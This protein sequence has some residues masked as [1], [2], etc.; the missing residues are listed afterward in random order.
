M[1]TEAVEGFSLS[2]QQ[3]QLWSLQR[4]NRRMPRRAQAA[5]LIEG[6]LDEAALDEAL[7]RVVRRHE[8]LRTEFQRPSGAEFPV[9]VIGDDSPPPVRRVRIDDAEG[10]PRRAWAALLSEAGGGAADEEGGPALRLSLARLSPER[11]LLHADL[12]SMSADAEGLSALVRE[13]ARAYAGAGEPDETLQ[14]AD[15]AESFNQ[16]AEADEMRTAAEFWR[17]RDFTA[18]LHASLPFESGTGAQG[19]F[20]P[21]LLELSIDGA[22]AGRVAAAAASV[23]ADVPLFMQTCWYVLLWKLTRET[24]VTAAVTFDGRAF[25][26]LGDLPGLFAQAVPVT[27]PVEGGIGLAEVAR[28]LKAANEEAR[29]RQ[30]AFSFEELSRRSDDGHSPVAFFPFG[31]EFTS[32]PARVEAGGLTWTLIGQRV[33]A[34]RF[35]VKLRCSGDAGRCDSAELQ[36]DRGRLSRES[37][38]RVARYYGRLLASAGS[39][40]AKVGELEMLDDAERRRLVYELNDTREG[41]ATNLCLHEPFEART[42]QD[43]DSVAL[44]FGSESLSYAQLDRRAATLARRLVASGLPPDATVAVLCRRSLEMPAA[45]LGVLKAGAAYLPLDPDYPA[46][47]LRFMLEDSGAR[48]LVAE[49]ELA[50]ELGA[51]GLP[52]VELPSGEAGW[53]EAEAAAPASDDPPVVGPDNLAYV[54]YTSGST[55]RP[56]GVMVT[57]RGVVN[58]LQWM[59]KAYGLDASDS[60][61]FK[62]SLGFDPSV[63][64]LFWPLWVGARCVIAEPGGQADPAYLL[65]LIADERVTSAYFVPS[66]LRE[67]VE[68]EGLEEAGRSLRRVICGGEALPVEVMRRFMERAPETELHHSYGPTETSIAATEWTCEAEAPRALMGRPLGNV[69]VYVLGPGME[70]LPEGVAG[71][72]F[73]GG[74][75]LARGYS[76]RPA[77]TAERFVPDPF[78]EGSGARLYRTGDVVRWAGPG[79]LLYVGRE[80]GQVKVRGFRIELGEV[81]AA[82]RR[83][84]AVSDAVV[85]ARESADGDKQLVAY[86]LGDGGPAPRA[87]EL[88]EHM[89]RSVPG[90]MIPQAFVALK[91]WPLTVTGKV[92]KKALPEPEAARQDGGGLTFRPMSPAEEVLAAIWSRVLGVEHVGP[93]DNFFDLGGDSIRSV[94]VVALAKERGLRL[95]VQQLFRSQTLA[96]LALDLDLGGGDADAPPTAPFSLVSAQDRALMP[97]DVEDAYPLSMMQAAMLYHMEMTTGAPAY[98][99]LS[100]WHVRARFDD[101]ALREAIRQVIARHAVLRTSFDVTTYSR[102]LQLVHRDA[103]TPYESEDV[104]HLPPDE[105]E[106]HIQRFLDERRDRVFD[107]SR[108][109]QVH[110]VAHRR[111]DD[112]F[113]LTL[114]ENHAVLDGWSVTSTLAEI[115]ERYLALIEGREAPSLSPPAA[116]FRDFVNLELHALASEETR[117]H[118]QRQ[119]SGAT[120]LRL[121]RPPR[122]AE[123]ADGRRVEKVQL[124]LDPEVLEGLKRAARSLAVPLKTVAFA[125]HLKVLSLLS[126]QTD[127]LAGITTNGRP[128][129]SGGTQVRGNFLNTVPFRFELRAETWG[130]MIRRVFEGEWAMLRHRRYPL[131]ALQKSWGRE[132]LLETNFAFLHFHSMDDVLSTGKVKVVGDEAIDLAETNFALLTHFDINSTSLDKR[133]W[134]DMQFDVTLTSPELRAAAPG[135]YD[136]VLRAIAADTSARHEADSYLS[137]EERER[138]LYEWNQTGAAVPAA[139]FQEMFAEQARRTPDAVAVVFGDERLTYRELNERADE[140]AEHLCAFDVGLDTLVAVMLERS[141]EMMVSLVG[142][143]K[144]GAAYLP[145]D[146]TN[147]A[148]RLSF[149]LEDSAAPVLLTQ[150]RLAERLPANA[151]RVIFADGKLEDCDKPGPH[152]P[153]AAMPAHTAYVIYTSGSTGKP[154][155]AAV[156]HRGL[157][158]YLHWC[159]G[160]Y[161]VGEGEGALVHSSIS[162][163]LTVTGLFA[164]L[165][166]GR[167][168]VLAP[169]SVGVEPLAESFRRW[170]DLSLVKI[171]PAQLQLLGGQL[172][173]A[174]AAGG[175]RRFVIGGENLQGETLRFWR[176]AA[177]ETVLINEYGPT[178]TV[179]GCCVHQVRAGE[180]LEGPV[181]IGRP[182]ANTRLYVLDKFMQPTPAGVPGELYIGGEGLARGYLRRPALTAERFVPDPF[183]REPGARL[184]RTGDVCRYRADGEL[185]FLGRADDQLKI[186]GYRIETGEV[187]AS[188]AQHA[189]VREAF[190]TAFEGPGGD[191]H[192]VA[193]LVAEGEPPAA[194]ELR[195]FLKLGLPEYMIP[196]AFVYLDALPLTVAGKVD[197]RALPAPDTQHPSLAAAYVAPHGEVEAIIADVWR[198]VLGVERVGA[199]DNFFDL[200]GDSFGVYEVFNK[201]RVAL[202]GR[203]LSILDLFTHPTVTTL[204]AHIE[205]L[206]G[207]RAEAADAE[208]QE[209]ARKRSLAD[210]RRAAARSR[211]AGASGGGE[212]SEP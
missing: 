105:Q 97:D 115:G 3:R 61:L 26:G 6:W 184:Y 190:V 117:A 57:H 168:V 104:R 83:H 85:V 152:I 36:Y 72:L 140:L 87:E 188:L 73:I 58:C 22:T 194:A 120:P 177:P 173:P 14:Y 108:P 202:G 94:R 69:T 131:G 191:K 18:A 79:G 70:L 93:D 32:A 128:E 185:E 102:P 160:A 165:L 5:A 82:L 186:H 139:C 154:K 164:P 110:F 8:I 103:G 53:A 29:D 132:T 161:R 42:A 193:Y 205:G 171:T 203:E 67:V 126:G 106:R 81:E 134:V 109:P 157:T 197:R 176:E 182:I 116:A 162:F 204:A 33:F 192:L 137:A 112:S 77:L 195:D 199:N 80:D 31:F 62:T 91:A 51:H 150:R 95:T 143:L 60:F 65:R 2:P 15:L 163:D 100:S 76:G 20:D 189:S 48:A 181:P 207:G 187:S 209:R 147:P 155:G 25:E 206:G 10:D 50:A 148:E 17:G 153:C 44:S 113:Q 38:E 56:K 144:A 114:V 52:L 119:L 21:D 4:A 13:V 71:E 27:C 68:A 63:W 183:S 16:I 125:A 101:G 7:G 211:R 135:Y 170:R 212:G 74:E 99:N 151:P 35:T 43:P 169:E 142:I 166:V 167:A 19:D 196:S 45:L 175:A 59:Q 88:R 159:L 208:A 49:P 129:Q 121:P 92:D 124:P 201:L 146:P 180:S 9:Q 39:A 64:E 30:L 158:N 89:K 54:I 141:P 130:Q 200:G 66:L 145:L 133:A 138:L 149:I 178:E 122:G 96:A 174:E 156:T 111:A 55:G 90:Y 23:G 86:V 78:S 179:V 24:E 198:E 107:L 127:L 41:Y 123:P 37:A 34:E 28:R 172:T 1:S 75:G 46:E 47:R 11:H 12:H 98:H 84:P 210:D 40:D 118:W 136:R